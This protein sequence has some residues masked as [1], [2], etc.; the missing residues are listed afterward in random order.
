MHIHEYLTQVAAA[1]T[2]RAPGPLPAPAEWETWRRR[3]QEQYLEMM[4]LDRYLRE[5]RPPLTAAVTRVLHRDGYRVECLA[6]ESL[7]GLWVA[8]NLYVPAG[9]GPHPAIL[10][11]CGHA[12]LQKAHY[13]EHGR[14]YAQLGFVTLVVDTIQLGEVRG[15]HHGPYRYGAFHWYSR[16]YTPAAVEAWNGI[17]GLDLLASRPEVDPQRLGVTGTSGGGAVTWWIAAAD[18]RV[19][20]AS[21]SCGTGTVAAHVGERTIDGHCDCM[22]PINAAGWCLVDFA[23]LIAPRPLLIVSA[24]RDSLFSISSIE[25]FHRRLAAVYRHLG[26]EA[27]LKLFTFR[28]GHSYQPASRRVTFHWFLRHLQGRDVPLDEVADVDGYREDPADLAVFSRGLP[29]NDRSTTVHDWFVPRAQPP[30]VADAEGLSRERARVVQ[31]LKRLT[32]ATFPDPLPDPDVRVVME[33]WSGGRILDF[34]YVPEEGWRLAGRL[35][36][37][38]GV[39]LPAP[40]V[41]ELLGPEARRQVPVPSLADGCPAGWL[42]ASLAP[43]GTG[44]TGWSEALQWHLRRAA[45]L[46]GRTLASLRVLDTCQGLAAIRR[47]EGVDPAQ[48]YLAARG[49]MAAVALYA[50]LLDGQ[51][52]GLILFDPPATQDV[53]SPPDG[54]GPVLE[55]LNCLRI[56]DLPQVA[57]LLWPAQLVFVGLRPASYLWA[58]DLYRRLGPPG[59]CW[60]VPELRY[61]RPAEPPGRTVTSPAEWRRQEGGVA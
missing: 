24:D 19:R 58:E 16:G 44:S 53:P 36:V 45:A 21:P 42:R 5:P 35:R 15:Y 30:V 10:Y 28:A 59:G 61:W 17:R 46:T 4:G 8:G 55:M 32:F 7:P 13:Q 50:A 9:P 54:S 49:E 60:N 3:R 47:L 1:I 26:A 48:V 12:E 56:T 23:A 39:S 38:E 2:G 37:P 51:V 31:E 11:V 22:F 34:T 41:V 57:G 29:A 25:D 40:V 18:D 20:V 33:S 14:R 43:R 52:A 6:Y 27:N